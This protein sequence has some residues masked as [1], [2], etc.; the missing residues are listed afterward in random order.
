MM[1]SLRRGWGSWQPPQT[2]SPIHIGHI[3]RVWAHWYAL[4]WHAVAALTV[5][6]VPTL[7]GSDF[8]VL[9]GHL[10]SQND[11]I[12]SWL[13]LAATSNCFPHP[14]YTYTK[15]LSTLICCPLAYSSSL[16]QLYPSYLAQILGFWVTC[17]VKMM[18]LRHGWGWQPP[19]TASPIHIRHIKSFWIHWYVVHWYAVATLHSCTHTT[20]FRFGGSGPLVEWKWCHYVMVEAGSHLKLLLPS[21][22][23]IQRVWAHW[24]VVHWHTVSAYTV[25]PNTAWLR[26]GGSGPLVESKWCCHYVMVEGDSHLKLLLSYIRYIQRDWAHYYA[27]HW[28]TVAAFLHSCSC[29][30]TTWL[31]FGGSG[32]V[33]YAIQNHVIMSWLSWQPPQINPPIHIRHIKMFDCIDMLSIGICYQPHTVVPTLLGSDL[34][35]LG[36]LWSENDV[37]RLDYFMVEADSH[38]K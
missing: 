29:T 21:I 34:G 8:G 17:G 19:Q 25:L 24:C 2:A 10:W 32:S 23:Q 13:R 16:K 27:L 4:H 33:S 7:L 18:S 3:Q 20:W 35:F 1:L 28:H 37:I 15:C 30:H 36:H 12:M 11:V 31:R 38:L 14:Y 26:F 5:V 6:L 22:R 9:L